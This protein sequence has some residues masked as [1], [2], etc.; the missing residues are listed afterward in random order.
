M[1]LQASQLRFEKI[2]YKGTPVMILEQEVR[3]MYHIQYMRTLVNR[4]GTEGIFCNQ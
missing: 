1:A 4:I 3:S 2:V